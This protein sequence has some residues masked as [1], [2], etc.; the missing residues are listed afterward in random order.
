MW[1]EYMVVEAPDYVPLPVGVT[2]RDIL[3]KVYAHYYFAREGEMNDKCYRI[4]IVVRRKDARSHNV[5]YVTRKD[6]YKDVLDPIGSTAG[7]GI[8][9]VD[10]G[11]SSIVSVK[12]IIF[13]FE[14]QAVETPTPDLVSKPPDT[15]QCN[16]DR[17]K[18]KVQR[19]LDE[20][21]ACVV[22]KGGAKIPC[23]EL[24]ERTLAQILFMC[25]GNDIRANFELKSLPRTTP[26]R[27]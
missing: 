2:A 19:I 24:G 27:T 7:H 26:L 18:E 9:L 15:V 4:A 12:T 6:Y 11:V 25:E 13:Y 3:R 23:K 8:R 5:H 21:Q 14:E 20:L 22:L 17:H 16:F 1:P 10:V